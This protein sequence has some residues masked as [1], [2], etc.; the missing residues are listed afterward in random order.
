MVVARPWVEG[1]KMSAVFFL[2]CFVNV[3]IVSFTK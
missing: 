2:F 3:Y 1:E